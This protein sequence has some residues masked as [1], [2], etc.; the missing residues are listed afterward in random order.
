M[1]FDEFFD[2]VVGDKV[3]NAEGEVF[4]ITSAQK[5]HGPEDWS[6]HYGSENILTR[7]FRAIREPDAQEYQNVSKL[8]GH[9]KE[10]AIKAALTVLLVENAK[11]RHS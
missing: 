5:T 3:F 6:A 11:R 2:L 7:K 1:H 4:E 10:P 8:L 9:V